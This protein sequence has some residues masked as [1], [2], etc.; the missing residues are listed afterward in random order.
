MYAEEKLE[1]VK[2][3][4]QYVIE[5]LRPT[6]IASIIAFA[7]KSR[8]VIPAGQ[9]TDRDMAKRI[10]KNINQIDVGSGTEMS[11]GI[12]AAVQEVK[13]NFTRDRVNHIIIL[14]D[15]LTQHEERCKQKCRDASDA[16]IS[17]STIGVGNDF[18]E[19]L[20]IE[21]A[22]SSRG[23]S[24]YIDHPKDI[25]GI[26]AQELTGV[27]SIV[28]QNLRV[29][30]NLTRD[31]GIRRAFK[32]KP[33][34]NDLGMVATNEREAMIKIGDLQKN[35]M[36]SLLLEMVLPS[37]QAGNF[38]IAQAHLIYDLPSRGMFEN[39][40]SRDIVIGYTTDPAVASVVNPEVMQI[41]D[42]VS[43]FKQQ[44]KALQLAQAGDTVKATQLLKSAATTL[45]EHGEKDLARQAM[46]EAERIEKGGSA[47]SGGTKKLEYGT[48]KLTQLLGK[49]P[50]S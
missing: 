18:N 24:Y 50:P 43:V 38:R 21:I 19:K 42:L 23:K 39:T 14:T 6:D 27:Q 44:T 16:Q 36:Q 10:I 45:L 7:D 29:K 30:L 40:I 11:T 13:K 25:P 37:R 35:E 5:Q 3:A 31:V 33:L 34:I 28:A 26:F 47:S 1:Y 49:L 32:V 12:D 48:R 15:G 4:V 46:Q 2:E 22:E 20:L 17:F 8:V 9:I 41:V